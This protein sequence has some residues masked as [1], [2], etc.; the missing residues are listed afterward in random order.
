MGRSAYILPGNALLAS[1][2]AAFTVPLGL[3][4]NQWQLEVQGCFEEALSAHQLEVTALCPW[5][6]R[7]CRRTG[8]SSTPTSRRHQRPCATHKSCATWESKVRN[9]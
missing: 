4:D 8:R 1:H 6:V 9:P 7:C 3:P 5:T 2:S